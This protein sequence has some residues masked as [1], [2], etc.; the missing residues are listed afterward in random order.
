[1]MPPTVLDVAVEQDG[2]CQKVLG[3]VVP[4]VPIGVERD[5]VDV[6]EALAEHLGLPVGIGRHVGVR[7]AAGDELE[8]LV[9]DLHAAPD[10]VGDPPVLVGGAVVHLPRP[11]H[12]VAETPDL[13]VVR[14]G[15]AVL[16]AQIAPVGA[17]RMVAVFE[18][19]EGFDEALG[20]EIDGEHRLRSRPCGTSG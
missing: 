17:A 1:M 20:A 4:I 6:V 16:A 9:E 19:G 12:L 7:G 10:L 3:V 15:R 2:L 11:V 8:R 14:L 5:V 18:H 13:H